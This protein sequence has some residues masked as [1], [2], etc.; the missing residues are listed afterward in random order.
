MIECS[1]EEKVDLP[2]GGFRRTTC[3]NKAEILVVGDPCFGLCYHCAYEKL[4]ERVNE[5]ERCEEIGLPMRVLLQI[6]KN[7]NHLLALGRIGAK[8]EIGEMLHKETLNL[9]RLI[10]DYSEISATGG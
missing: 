6:L 4:V 1:F 8:D 7:Q 10:N 2:D 9:M 5:L 3:V